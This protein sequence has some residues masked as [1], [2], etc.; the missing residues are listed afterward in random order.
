[1]KR[2]FILSKG[3]ESAAV[4]EESLKQLELDIMAGLGEVIPG[5][6]GFRKVRVPQ[7]RGGKRGGWRA[8]FADYPQYDVTLLIMAYR[9][10]RQDNL[11]ADE[12]RKLKAL[13]RSLDAAMERRFGKARE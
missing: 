5:T 3:F 6:G 1:M 8:I 12:A 9:K 10:A 7:L 2:I 13:K 4:P 11:T